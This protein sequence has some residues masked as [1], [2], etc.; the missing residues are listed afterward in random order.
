MTV[1]G[2]DLTSVAVHIMEITM[3]YKRKEN[4]AYVIVEQNKFFS[5][6]FILRLITN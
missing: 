5:V 2:E 4:D 3:I 1:E 6:S